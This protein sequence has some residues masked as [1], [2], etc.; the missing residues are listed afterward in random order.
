M[1]EVMKQDVFFKPVAQEEEKQ[2]R[3]R[4]AEKHIEA[5]ICETRLNLFSKKW[6][7]EDTHGA[8]SSQK[9]NLSERW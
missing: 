4:K 5:R 6:N 7:N 9:R 8:W 2:H 1:Q 3:H